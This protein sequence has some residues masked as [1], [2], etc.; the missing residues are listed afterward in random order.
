MCTLALSG[1][2]RSPPPTHPR[3]E[4]LSVTAHKC[5][6]SHQHGDWPTV[7][8]YFMLGTEREKRWERK[9]KVQNR[10]KTGTSPAVQCLR[11]R[12]TTT[13]GVGL[14]PSQE[15]KIPP[16]LKH[17]QKEKIKKQCFFNWRK[18]KLGEE[19]TRLAQFYT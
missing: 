18:I 2:C 3:D 10:R 14:N 13:E 1:Q 4:T 6:S 11:L 7:H 17:S 16:A 19:V 15:T 5:V 9:R 12:P 8:A